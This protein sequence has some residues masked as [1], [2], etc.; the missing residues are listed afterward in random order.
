MELPEENLV[1]WEDPRLEGMPTN[2]SQLQFMRKSTMAPP[3]RIPS[4]G[5]GL[6]EITD[7]QGNSR[8]KPMSRLPAAPNL[9]HKLGGPRTWNRCVLSL[10]ILI[11]SSE[12]ARTQ[13][14]NISRKGRRGQVHRS[15]HTKL[16]RTRKGYLSRRCRS[17]FPEKHPFHY[18]N[19]SYSH[20]GSPSIAE[21][22]LGLWLSA[23]P[24]LF[25]T[26]HAF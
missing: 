15:S 5:K 1:C 25:S 19:A 16:A 21:A 10:C 7:S 6:S 24:W 9:K 2:T 20:T 14:Q 8:S 13:T 23:P 11:R 17:K 12:R 3:S 4:P 26:Q 22:R 18:R